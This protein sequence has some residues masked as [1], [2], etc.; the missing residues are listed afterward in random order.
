MVNMKHQ[1]N[2]KKICRLFL[3]LFAICLLSL[4][5][6]PLPFNSGIDSSPV[7]NLP[8]G[9]GSFSLAVS[10]ASRTLMPETPVLGD[11]KCL[12]LIFRV[13]NSI[14]KNEEINN[15]NGVS[16]LPTVNLEQGTYSLTINAYKGPGKTNL[17]ARG[18][19]SEITI[20][21][22][23]NTS[24]SVILKALLTEGEG[25]FIWNITF[26]A[27]V[28]EGYIGIKRLGDT[29]EMPSD[30]IDV[31]TGLTSGSQTL[32]S[33]VYN[34][35]FDLSSAQ[36]L[37]L[38]WNELV[39][40]YSSLDTVFNKVFDEGYFYNTHHDVTFVFNNGTGTNGTQSVIHGDTVQINNPVKT[41]STA[42]LHL[43]AP[44]AEQPGFVF[45]GWYSDSACTIPWIPGTSVVSNTTLYAKWT[46][47]IDVSEQGGANDVEKA[48]AYV[49][50][51]AAAGAAYT[52]F[53][54]DN[55]SIAPHTF[56]TSQNLTIQGLGA[57]ERTIQYSGAA[58]S[59]LFTIDNPSASLTLGENVTLQG[60]TNGTTSLVSVTSGTLVMEEGSKITGHTNNITGI[61]NKDHG[62][63]VSVFSG[64]TFTM[65]GGEIS[66][67]STGNSANDNGGGVQV[68]SGGTF[69]MSGGTI[70]GNTSSYGGGVSVFGDENN[71]SE[72][73]NFYMSGGEIS[74]NITTKGGGGV[75]VGENGSFIM[76]K[77]VISGNKA[78]EDGGGG[79]SVWKGTFTMTGGEISG[80]YA[81]GDNNNGGG[82][83]VSEGGSFNMGG[84]K[85]SNNDAGSGGG[86]NVWMGTFTLNSGEISDNTAGEFGGGVNVSDGGT[87][88]MSGGTVGGAGTGE[89]NT[90]DN[91][92]GGVYI[93]SGTFT[94][95]GGT[96]SGNRGVKDGGGVYI[97]SGTF[98]MTGGA[99]SDNEA[100]NTEINSANGGGVYFW[101][102]TFTVGGTAKILNNTGDH[103]ANDVHLYCDGDGSRYITLGTDGDVPVAG[104]E[105]W[106]SLNRPPNTHNGIIVASG[107]NAGY[108]QYFHADEFGKGVEFRQANGGQL[109]IVV[110]TVSVAVG[111]PFTMGSPI[112]EA[113]RRTDETQHEVTLTQGFYMSK[114]QVTQGQY[115]DVMGSLPSS[116]ISGNYGKGDNYP[117]YYVS[118]YDAIEF[119]NALSAKEG[120]TSYY[121]ITKTV[122]SDP[123]N[124]GSTDPYRWLVTTNSSANGYRLPTEAEWEYA[125]RGGALNTTGYKIYSGSNNVNDVAWWY[126][127][128]NST[129]NSEMK[130]HEVGTKQPN[131]LGIYDMSGNVWEW[132]WDWYGSYNGD[133]TDPTGASS[134]SDR[135]IRGGGYRQ[136]TGEV[137]SACRG[138][139]IYPA[140]TADDIGFRVVLPMQ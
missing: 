31:S 44:P 131:E 59:P 98:K 7:D 12:E 129:G 127:T 79:V 10:G 103:G 54:C 72:R 8:P 6:C 74:G 138:D 47:A 56:S 2:R 64:G 52:L 80:N 35:T 71:E 66:G 114:Y 62:G 83:N 116:L 136:P 96:M 28:N 58:G 65:T 55:V 125:A 119:C 27:F 19:L 92:G 15:Y 18:E 130:T 134:G 106:V 61:A 51:N 73:G 82:V 95:S 133:A 21:A 5:S 78:G 104:M 38:K 16:P 84:G 139:G 67:N 85:I 140:L 124:T 24:A 107:A 101:D 91:H 113:G 17:A 40:I 37:S 26:P 77:G 23:Q 87:F 25:T 33:G 128:N 30:P 68:F 13:G 110:D 126:D 36:H 32:N 115:Q 4:A 3:L 121:T 48:I 49:N 41:S 90:A 118:W 102:G 108:V 50:A 22:G 14:A 93:T 1:N 63:G 46:G 86:V 112:T 123:S 53:V 117:V 57:G 97:A 42:Y 75:C 39:Y 99:I 45:A 81:T 69:N 105:I 137:R 88:N 70:T 135:V 60:A 11:F 111:A 132:C 120:L 29:G 9:M 100:E 89:G 109:I 94:M 34:V 122:D 43:G 20:I 76:N